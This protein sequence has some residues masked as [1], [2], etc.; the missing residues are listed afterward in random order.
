MIQIIEEGEKLQISDL[1]ALEATIGK[2]LPEAYRQFLLAHNGGRP[3]PA[4]IDID[5]SPENATVVHVLL[6]VT[7]PFESETLGWSWGAFQCRIPERLLPIA[8]D[9]FGNL[10]CLSLA[11][12]DEGQVLFLDRYEEPSMGPHFVAKDFNAF[13]AKLRPMNE[14]ERALSP[15]PSCNPNE[16]I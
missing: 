8:D 13:L 9:P 15:T 16:S 4:I 10:F 14:T 12:D 7:G 3:V 2:R 6:G 1:E 11:C 5:D